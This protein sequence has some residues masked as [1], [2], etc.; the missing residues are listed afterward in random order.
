MVLVMIVTIRVPKKIYLAHQLTMMTI[1][2]RNQQQ[3]T[4]DP[5][6]TRKPSGEIKSVGEG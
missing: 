2:A 4:L 3:A 5:S 1:P 6:P